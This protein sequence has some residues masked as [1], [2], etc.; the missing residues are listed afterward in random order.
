VPLFHPLGARPDLPEPL[1]RAV[2]QA[3]C[4]GS[5]VPGGPALERA[6]EATV[7]EHIAELTR[8][9]ERT[10]EV[11][12]S[13]EP[14]QFERTAISSVIVGSPAFISSMA[15]SR[16]K[17]RRSVASAPGPGLF[18]PMAPPPVAQQRMPVPFLPQLPVSASRRHI[19]RSI[20][21]PR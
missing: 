18:N 2:R 6:H 19:E 9:R 10:L 21:S 4:L 7:A 12:S 17:S 3:S 20:R 8:Q 15:A 11:I 1:L 5:R 13:I 14:A 16:A